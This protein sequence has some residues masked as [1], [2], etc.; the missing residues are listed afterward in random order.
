MR[1]ENLETVKLK[2]QRIRLGL[3]KATG[4]HALN[5]HTSCLIEV[6]RFT[7]DNYLWCITTDLNSADISRTHNAKVKLKFV[8]KEEGLFM[9]LTGRAEII[10][11]PAAGFNSGMKSGSLQH[12]PV[13]MKIKIDN[14]DCFQKRSTSRYTSFLQAVSH[15]GGNKALALRGL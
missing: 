15:F 2:I 11:A 7:D 3:L 5:I 4:S 12:K 9:K 10:D 14:A 13:M 8:R 6:L 1:I